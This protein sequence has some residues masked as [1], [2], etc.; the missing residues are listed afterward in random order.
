[1][2]IRDFE[3]FVNSALM[4]TTRISRAKE[5][6]LREATTNAQKAINIVNIMI[7]NNKFVSYL[8]NFRE[9]TKSREIIDALSK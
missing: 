2:I 8:T 3:S 7:N 9:I 6:G 5:H 1:M 4:K